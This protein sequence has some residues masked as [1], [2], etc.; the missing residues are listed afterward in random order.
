MTPA[1]KG[2]F[3]GSCQKQVIDF[4]HM[5]DREIAQFFKKPST[6]SVCGR[7]M[8]DQLERNIA[9]PKRRIPWVKY[10][11][12]FA[13]PAFLV[14]LKASAQKERPLMGKVSSV[15]VRPLMGEI[16]RIPVQNLSIDSTNITGKVID[17]KGAPI[18]FASI[19]VKG[20]ENGKATD[21][22]GEFSINP[23]ARSGE[24]IIVVSSAGFE[25]KEVSIKTGEFKNLIIQLNAKQMLDGVVVTSDVSTLKGAIV[26]CTRISRTQAMVTSLLS[27][28]SVKIYPNPVSSGSIINIEVLKSGHGKTMVE[29]YN[30]TGQRVY[31]TEFNLYDKYWKTTLPL[32]ALAAGAYIL[33][34]YLEKMKKTYAEKIIIQ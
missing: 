4:S 1:D 10:F 17:E 14:S 25:T 32:P 19:L 33:K 15:C 20:T 29:L 5:N 34:V 30:M 18:P 22:K 11:F 9:I 3:C 31:F 27:K 24:L 7:F 16:A 2:K 26:I 23:K 13:L 12:Q 28:D 6:G 21:E 8:N